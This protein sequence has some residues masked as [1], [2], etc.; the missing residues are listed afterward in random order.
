MSVF[1]SH[2]FTAAGATISIG[3]APA[4][5]DLTGFGAVTFT[6]IGEVTDIGEYGKNYKL[7]THNPLSARNTIKRKGSYDSGKMSL[8]MAH[9]SGDAGQAALVA[10]RDSDSSYSFKVVLQSGEIAYFTAQV[11][12]YMTT[13]GTVD[14]IVAAAVDLELDNDVLNA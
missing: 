10:A 7:V 8:K 4:T 2:A 12:G 14:Q 9:V 1:V 13:V 6:P 11:M 5:Y 3:P